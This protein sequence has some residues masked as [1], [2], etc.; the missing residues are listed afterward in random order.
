MPLR[1]RCRQTPRSPTGTTGTATKHLAGAEAAPDRVGDL[2]IRGDAERALDV[3]D[4]AASNATDTGTTADAQSTD[5][6][7]VALD[8]PRLASADN[9]RDLAGIESTYVAGD[10]TMRSE[11]IYRSNALDLSDEDL[12]TLEDLGV[13]TVIDLRT[14]QQ[15]EE[16]PDRVPE[17]AEYVHI[18]LIGDQANG[19]NTMS[20]ISF[21]T[22]ESAAAI[23]EQT[24]VGFV[25]DAGQRERF[26][27]VL[28]T[29]AEADG[30]ILFHCTAGKDRAGWTSAIL[31][32]AA[33]VSEQDVMANYLAT[34]DYSEERIAATAD[35]VREAKGD[36][37]ADAIKVLLGVQESFL[38]AGLDAMAEKY[39]DID[40]HL[41]EGL[42]LDEDTVAALKDRLVA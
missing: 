26:G 18:D 6:T 15:V 17:G 10:S 27:E 32:L 14:A 38:Q 13:S 34:N 42:G 23:L 16:T 22:P 3:V 35:K 4:E 41:S 37:A 28:T 39:G 21:D 30:S 25:E 29:I 2:F 5:I 9:F 11:T 19:A 36:E 40:G 12:A 24:N 1:L 33:G 8:T 7:P 31:Q 20:D